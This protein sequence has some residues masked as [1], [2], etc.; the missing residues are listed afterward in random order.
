V[1]ANCWRPSAD[2]SNCRMPSPGDR[3]RA[4]LGRGRPLVLPGVFDALSARLAFASGF[5]ALYMSGFGVSA[6]RAALPDT[7]MLTMSEMVDEATA[8]V[9]ATG[10]PLLA[11]ADTGYGHAASV[12][13]TI[14][15]YE[16]AGVAGVHIEDTLWPREERRVVSRPELIERAEAALGARR[17]ASFLIVGRTDAY[18]TLG[19][20]EAID[21]VRLLESIGV[22]AIFVHSLTQRDE[23][24]QLRAATALPL[25]ANVVDGL[26]EVDEISE[27]AELGYEL[28]IFSISA[29]RSVVRTTLGVYR[30]LADAGHLP[31]QR[32]HLASLEETLSLL[33]ATPD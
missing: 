11:D 20:D 32:G 6:S 5:E 26:T 16:Q 33:Q 12:A 18:D 15:R 23:F 31:G 3:F 24:S 8:I 17:H 13:R 28:V 25:V 4:L 29:L 1:S 19:L 10:L 9:D 14:R 7:G 27:F 2:A 30:E 22:D 21:R